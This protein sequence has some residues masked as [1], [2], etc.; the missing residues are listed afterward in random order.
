MIFFKSVFYLKIH[1][2]DV[3]FISVHQNHRKTL[4]KRIN[5]MHFQTKHDSKC[6]NKH[7]FSPSRVSNE[8]GYNLT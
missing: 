8:I 3:F 6:K 1:Q 7:D 5:L 4:N 2:T